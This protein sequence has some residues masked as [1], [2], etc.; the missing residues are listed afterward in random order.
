MVGLELSKVEQL[1]VC[2]GLE[3]PDGLRSSLYGAVHRLSERGR[4]L[5]HY[6]SHNDSELG[7]A[8]LVGALL[9]VAHLGL[10]ETEVGLVHDARHKAIG[11]DAVFEGW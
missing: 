6:I 9:D 3:A 8:R 2:I 1:P 11:H 4:E 10:L 7:L 5:S